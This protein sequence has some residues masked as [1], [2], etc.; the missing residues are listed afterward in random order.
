M[1]YYMPDIPYTDFLSIFVLAALVILFG[2]GYAGFFTLVKLKL[3]KRYQMIFAY[4]SWSIQ[5]VCMYYLGYLLKVEPYTQKVL[6]G[7]M[8]GYLIF[9]HI[10]YFILEQVHNR[11]E[12]ETE[13]NQI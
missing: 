5:A 10:V 12:K 8:I 13:I 2:T 1:E 11:Y 3:V 4:I 7:A 6:V 9:P